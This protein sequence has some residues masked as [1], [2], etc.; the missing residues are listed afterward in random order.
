[1]PRI[2]RYLIELHEPYVSVLCDLAVA[3]ERTHQQETTWIVKRYLEDVIRAQDT[4]LD[5]FLTADRDAAE[6]SHA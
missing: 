6:V 4:S 2:L 3:H 5:T 1:M